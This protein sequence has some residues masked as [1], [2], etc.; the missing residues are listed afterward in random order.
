MNAAVYRK[1]DPK[2]YVT[3]CLGSSVRSDGRGLQ[4]AR[5]PALTA[6]SISSA[7]GSSMVKLGR[8]T[9]VAGVTAT[10]AHP[11]PGVPEAGS[12]DVNVQVLPLVSGTGFAGGLAQKAELKRVGVP[13]VACLAEFLREN[14][15]NFVDLEAL[16]IEAGHLVWELCLTVYCVDFD[17]CIEDALLLS[18]WVALRNVRLP[19]I[20]PAEDHGESVDSPN[21]MGNGADSSKDSFRETVLAVATVERTEKLKIKDYCLS[22]SFAIIGEHL[23][24]DPSKEEELVADARLILVFQ[25]SGELRAVQK[26]GGHSVPLDTIGNCVEIA[27]ARLRDL[28]TR[29]ESPVESN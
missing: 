6:G 1:L 20:R 11:S 13:E 18:A 23:L 27:Q 3:H 21:I 26:H 2:S 5:R 9:V 25:P 7:V 12:L 16:C 17:G 14:I 4:V 8:T 29:L 19:A 24:L 28:V 10:V 15:F 22:V